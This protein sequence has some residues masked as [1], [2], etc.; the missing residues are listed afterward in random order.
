MCGTGSRRVFLLRLND[1][2][3]AAFRNT[4]RT[5]TRNTTDRRNMFTRILTDLYP[6][7]FGLVACQNTRTLYSKLIETNLAVNIKQEVKVI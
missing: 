5:T 6:V 3:G 1:V 7:V 4:P 2:V